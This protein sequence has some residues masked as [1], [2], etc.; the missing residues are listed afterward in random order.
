MIGAIARAHGARWEPTLTGFKWIA[1]RALEIEQQSGGRFVLGF[2]EAL[3]YTVGTLVRDKDGIG[4]AAVVCDLAG[5][6]RRRGVTLLDELETAW[7]RYGLY[8][9]RTISITLPGLDG[10]AKIARIMDTVR[11]APPDR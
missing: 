3:G 10:A 2:E 5:W 1:N 4:A 6:C 9:S 8:L 7:R 11:R